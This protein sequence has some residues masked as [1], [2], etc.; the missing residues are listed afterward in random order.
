MGLLGYLR[1]RTNWIMRD[2]GCRIVGSQ[3]CYTN[4]FWLVGWLIKNI[5]IFKIIIIINKGLLLLSLH[6]LASFGAYWNNLIYVLV[7][8]LDQLYKVALLATPLKIFESLLRIS[9]IC[10]YYNALVV[11]VQ[12]RSWYASTWLL[13]FRKHIE[14]MLCVHWI[15]RV[16]SL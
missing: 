9:L 15:V 7:I 5:Y 6:I 13:I 3:E 8:S 16:R 2:S 1:V 11:F 4:D 10:S 12:T 14:H